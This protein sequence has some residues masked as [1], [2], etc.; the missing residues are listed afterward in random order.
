MRILCNLFIKKSLNANRFL[1]VF[2]SITTTNISVLV[3][4]SKLFATVAVANL[5]ADSPSSAHPTQQVASNQ[6]DVA[7]FWRK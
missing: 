6:I 2:F 1:A 7:L 3:A 4:A 5:K